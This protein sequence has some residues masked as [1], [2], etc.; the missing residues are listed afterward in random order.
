[1]AA[2]LVEA[3]R[4]GVTGPAYDGLLLGRDWGG[5]DQDVIADVPL[6]CQM[7]HAVVVHPLKVGHE[8]LGNGVLLAY[9]F[10]QLRPIL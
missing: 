10:D 3:M 7:A 4:Q 6:T 1:M 8:H 5:I 2:S 9:D